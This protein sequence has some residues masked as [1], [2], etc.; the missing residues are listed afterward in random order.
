[1]AKKEE[2]ELAVIP[3]D[4][5]TF[6]LAVDDGPAL[7]ADIAATIDDADL[8]GYEE[9]GDALPY[10]TIRQKEESDDKGKLLY[11]PGGFRFRDRL[12]NDIIHDADGDKGLIVSILADKKSRVWFEKLNDAQPKCKSFDGDLGQGDPGGDCVRCPLNQWIR[13]E[14]PTC[15]EQINLLCMDHTLMIAYVLNLGR[16]GLR[17][18]NDFKALL[19]R[20][21]TKVGNDYYRV[22]IHYYCFRITTQ[23]VKDPSPHYVPVFTIVND[24]DKP[25]IE[26]MKEYRAK[27]DRRFIR[28]VETVQ[29]SDDDDPNRPIDTDFR[30]VGNNSEVPPGVTRVETDDDKK[31]S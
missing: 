25:A 31:P 16:S 26:M 17:P 30:D 7:P 12:T 18:Y 1:M 10:V 13:G 11:R 20:R 28:T 15:A 6:D 27:M 5:Q 29:A 9:V 2:K 24:L 4:Y 14:R 22:P 21:K 8:E 3:A 19:K 23:F